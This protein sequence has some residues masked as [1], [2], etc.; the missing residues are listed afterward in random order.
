MATSRIVRKEEEIISVGQTMIFVSTF[1]G[2]A[3]FFATYKVTYLNDLC[4]FLGARSP[5]SFGFR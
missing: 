5:D 1:L 2:D 4:F 3:I